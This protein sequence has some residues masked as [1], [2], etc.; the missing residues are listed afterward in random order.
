ML[1]FLLLRL[2]D[3]GSRKTPQRF[4]RKGLKMNAT[5][6]IEYGTLN[7]TL[8]DV[9]IFRIKVCVASAG[10]VM[11]FPGGKKDKDGRPA[12]KKLW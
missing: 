12:P 3:S 8:Y 11:I 2:K 4:P 7:S 9:H 10:L 1:I 5:Y 6:R